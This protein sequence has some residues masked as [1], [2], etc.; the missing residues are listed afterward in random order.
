MT[1]DGK[2][3][4]ARGTPTYGLTDEE[5]RRKEE[6]ERK[7]YESLPWNIPIQHWEGY[8]LNVMY[9]HNRQQG[10][11]ALDVAEKKVKEKLETEEKS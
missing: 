3:P 2:P 1:T 10:I 8:E 5:K 4:P 11:R 7:E 6:Y 9:R